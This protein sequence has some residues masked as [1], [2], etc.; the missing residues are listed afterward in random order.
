MAAKRAN[1]QVGAVKWAARQAYES[2]E[3]GEC[4]GGVSSRKAEEGEKAGG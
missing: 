1:R 2:E 3:A 4:C